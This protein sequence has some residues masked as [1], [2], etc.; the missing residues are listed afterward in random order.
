MAPSVVARTQTRQCT[1]S[2]RGNL[3]MERRCGAA[4]W[5]CSRRPSLC[6]A[7]PSKPRKSAMGDIVESTDPFPDP[8]TADL[9]EGETWEWAG[10]AATVIVPLLAVATIGLGIFAASQYNEGATEFLQPPSSPDDTARI[11]TGIQ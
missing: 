7:E 1:T 10:K 9:W 2:G 8:P 5:R 3:S 6:R 11:I 4:A